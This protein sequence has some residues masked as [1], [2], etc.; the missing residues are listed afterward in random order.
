MHRAETWVLLW[1]SIAIPLISITRSPS[2]ERR[3]AAMRYAGAALLLAAGSYLS[4]APLFASYQVAQGEFEENNNRLESSLA[5]Y[6][7]ALHWNP[8]SPDA[9]FDLTRA[10]AKIGDDSGALAQSRAATR[11]VDEPELYILRSRILLNVDRKTDA[12][13]ELEEAMRLFPYSMEIRSEIASLSQPDTKA[14]GH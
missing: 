9:N 10:L 11:F 7:S 6:R 3:W 13:R 1:I 4:F 14:G 8:S 5:T 2:I 12:R